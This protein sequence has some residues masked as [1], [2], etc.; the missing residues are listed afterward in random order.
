M[1]A[2]Q[3]LT[4][5]A[6]GVMVARPAM[7]PTHTPTNDGLPSKTHSIA[8]HTCVEIKILRRVRAES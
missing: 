7:A 8:I 1:T 2:A 4:K 3:G 5:P 6:A